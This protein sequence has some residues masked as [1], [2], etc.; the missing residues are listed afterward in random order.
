MAASSID[1]Q[2]V[3]DALHDCH[4]DKD[5]WSY[6]KATADPYAVSA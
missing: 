5:L 3:P 2:F 1:L 6:Y 4:D